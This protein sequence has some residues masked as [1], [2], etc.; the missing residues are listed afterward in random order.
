MN[1]TASVQRNE[2]FDFD[3]VDYTF[4]IL[5]ALLFM[6]IGM[7]T[8]LDLYKR[9]IMTKKLG[10]LSV[11]RNLEIFNRRPKSDKVLKTFDGVRALS[12][13]WVV[14]GH[15]LYEPIAS[16]VVNNGLDIFNKWPKPIMSLTILNATVSGRVS[17]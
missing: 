17:Y 10:F 13:T 3:A 15:G 7:V 8:I 6:V 2:T 5:T 12:M 14:I 1:L 16:G 11:K 4:T 9:D